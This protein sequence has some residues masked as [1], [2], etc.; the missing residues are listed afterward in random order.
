MPNLCPLLF[1]NFIWNIQFE[2]TGDYFC[3]DFDFK[4]D[5]NEFLTQS[6]VNNSQKAIL[7]ER[8]NQKLIFKYF[9]NGGKNW[10]KK[11]SARKNEFCVLI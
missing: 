10:K 1:Q 5:W 3:Q 7:T 8:L 9:Q 2:M 6:T 4:L 11:A